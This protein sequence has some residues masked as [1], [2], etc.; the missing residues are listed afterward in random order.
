MTPDQRKQLEEMARKETGHGGSGGQS[1]THQQLS[2]RFY[3]TY[4][5]GAQA[6]MDVGTRAE[7]E[8]IA[9]LMEDCA[10]VIPREVV[11]KMFNPTPRI[12][13]TEERES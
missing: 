12:D 6:G 1:V 10:S 7:R 5:A 13:G 3:D 8:R 11:L 2:R 9:M 4:M